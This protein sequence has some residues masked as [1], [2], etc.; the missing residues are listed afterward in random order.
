MLA[1]IGNGEIQTAERRNPDRIRF[2]RAARKRGYASHGMMHVEL[3][4][5]LQQS[6][7]VLTKDIKSKD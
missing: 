7:Q 4:Y 6:A 3:P 1:E 5:C 2:C